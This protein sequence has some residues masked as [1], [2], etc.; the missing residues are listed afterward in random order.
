MEPI[1]QE[2]KVVTF[3]SNASPSSSAY[4]VTSTTPQSAPVDMASGPFLPQIKEEVVG[5]DGQHLGEAGK[6]QRM[7]VDGKGTFWPERPHKADPALAAAGVKANTVLTNL[8]RGNIPTMQTIVMEPVVAS[9]HQRAGQGELR[10]RELS[11]SPGTVN[12][13]DHRRRT[14]LIWSAAY[15]QTPTVTLLVS[16][17]AEVNAEG[18]EGETAL[19]MAAAGGH[20]DAVKALLVRGARPDAADC[21][22][23]TP[24][25]FAAAENHPHACNELLAAGADVAAVNLCD[26]T[27]ISLAIK[28]E[29]HMAQA[30]LEQHVMGL[31]KRGGG[32]DRHDLN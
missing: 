21:N 30:V 5:A 26:D 6:Q 10:A 23:C 13:R 27:A 12:E 18:D 14:P 20:H 32:F 1:E 3:I 24:L 11:A 7:S 17:G 31:M 4:H 16:H 28:R 19:H 29:A 8:Q 2:Y 22:G 9:L 15:G 25:M